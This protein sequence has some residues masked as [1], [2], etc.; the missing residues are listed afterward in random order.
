AKCGRGFCRARRTL[1]RASATRIRRC[2][3]SGSVRGERRTRNRFVSARSF[4]R[5]ILLALFRGFTLRTRYKRVSNDPR[6]AG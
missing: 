4:A 2:M 5:F 6:P 3:P 1:V